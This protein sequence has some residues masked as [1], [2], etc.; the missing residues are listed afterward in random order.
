MEIAPMRVSRNPLSL[1]SFNIPSQSIPLLHHVFFS[2]F[3]FWFSN[4]KK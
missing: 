1:V 4:E 3:S 2:S